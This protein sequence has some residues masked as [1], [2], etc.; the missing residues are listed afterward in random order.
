MDYTLEREAQEFVSL[1]H[2]NKI[3]W[4]MVEDNRYVLYHSCQGLKSKLSVS[5]GS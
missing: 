2:R 1:S 4:I 5:A 3:T